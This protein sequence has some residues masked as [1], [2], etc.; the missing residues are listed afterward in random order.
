[1]C[2]F[3]AHIKRHTGDNSEKPTHQKLFHW[4][5]IKIL[6]KDINP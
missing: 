1:M 3:L 2:V 5:K 6:D 4:N